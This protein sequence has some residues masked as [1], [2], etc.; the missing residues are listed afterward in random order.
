MMAY[1]CCRME[2][3]VY[4][5]YSFAL[6]ILEAYN[7]ARPP[8]STSGLPPQGKVPASL[9]NL[10]HKMMTPNAKSRMPTLQVLEAGNADGGFFKDNRLVK[11]AQGLESFVLASEG[12][13]ATILK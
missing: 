10:V 9:Y 7:G 8:S 3:H 6:L 1:I 4:D 12:E 11:V 2:P 5:S 13:R